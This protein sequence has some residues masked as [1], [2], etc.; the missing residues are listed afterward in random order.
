MV[1]LR[2]SQWIVNDEGEMIMGNGRMRILAC[3][4]E[5]GSINKAAK[6]MKMSYK[7][8]WAKLK[9]TEESFGKPL[10]IASKRE[11]TRLTDEGRVLLEKFKQLKKE[12]QILD[13]TAFKEIFGKDT[14]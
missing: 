5:T 6:K 1:Q 8:V 11:G 2:S 7:A 12:C 4:D 10:V 3:I 9:A 14:H 13:D